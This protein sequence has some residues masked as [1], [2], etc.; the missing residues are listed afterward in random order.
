M[1]VPRE[2]MQWQT[3]AI[4][5]GDPQASLQGGSSASAR[6]PAPSTM[7]NECHSPHRLLQTPMRSVTIKDVA[8]A[9]GVNPSTVSKALRGL[10]GKVSPETRKRI[11]QV[12]RELG[13]R[14]NAVA[15]T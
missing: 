8:K 6:D 3:I 10:A 11:E 5:V 4:N 12:A 15:A 2:A 9:A 13:Y 1:K 14:H 7:A